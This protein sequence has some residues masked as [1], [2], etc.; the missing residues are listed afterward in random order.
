MKTYKEQ[1]NKLTEAYINL[2][3]NP[4]TGCNCFVGNLLGNGQWEFARWYSSI[5]DKRIPLNKCIREE[6]LSDVKPGILGQYSVLDILELERTFLTKFIDYIHAER[7]CVDL[8][9]YFREIGGTIEEWE[10]YETKQEEGLFLAFE[11]ALSVL[12]KIHIKN[13]ETLDNEPTFVKRELK[14]V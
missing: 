4:F 11:A 9:Q 6:K 5:I 1:Y 7:F 2:K 12:R 14:L 3:V 10:N 13:G 8:R